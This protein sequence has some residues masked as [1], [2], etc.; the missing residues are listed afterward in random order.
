MKY[1]WLLLPAVSLL[2]TGCYQNERNCTKFHN[3]TFEFSYT[4]EGEKRSSTFVRND[5]MEIDFYENRT[6]TNSVRWLND[7]EFIVKKLNA[8]SIREEKPI[9]IKILSTSDNSYIFEYSL[10]GDN[11]N[12]QKGKAT[13][14]N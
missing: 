3:G 7:C 10:V 13:K 8:N 12:K 5:S 9:H 1:L 2:L 14:I 6:D 4:I 11:K